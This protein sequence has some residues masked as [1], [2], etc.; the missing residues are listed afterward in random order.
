MPEPTPADVRKV[1]SSHGYAFQYAVLRRAEEL[2]RQ[3][4]SSWVFEAA[5][6]PVGELQNTI[7]IDF[8]LRARERSVYLVAECKRVDPARASWCFAKAPYTRRNAYEN[9]LVFQEVGYLPTGSSF[10]CPRTKKAS[11]ASCHLGFE[12][13]TSSKGD[14]TTRGGS[15]IND[16]TTQVLRAV[17]GL[18]NHLFQGPLT[19][20]EEEGKNLFRR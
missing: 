8:I 19:A 3:N 4:R 9:E 6:F 2:S 7:H 14:G 1:L 12:L 15:A 20:V 5:E 18:V 16:A 17:N 13:R 10:S 11:L